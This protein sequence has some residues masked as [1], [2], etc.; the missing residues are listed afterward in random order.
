[1]DT[2]QAIKIIES[3]APGRDVISW[4]DMREA[5]LVAIEALHEKQEH[6]KG[7]EFCST[8]RQHWSNC[9]NH[10]DHCDLDICNRCTNFKPFRVARYCEQCGRKLNE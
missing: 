1:M 10:D 2:K 8:K 6:E 7:C 5:L 3:Y 9:K 4:Y